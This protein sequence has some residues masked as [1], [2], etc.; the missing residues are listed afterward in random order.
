[1]KGFYYYILYVRVFLDITSFHNN[2]TSRLF[3]SSRIVWLGSVNL[4]SFNVSLVCLSISF[5]FK[6][7][8]GKA[9]L[10]RVTALVHKDD[11]QSVAPSDS[12]PAS[13]FELSVFGRLAGFAFVQTAL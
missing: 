4:V 13:C 2:S 1:M 5:A 7:K 8:F 10:V 9:K 6:V 3:P 12:R 11:C